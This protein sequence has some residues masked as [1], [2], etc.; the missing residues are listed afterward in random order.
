MSQNKFKD[1]TKIDNATLVRNTMK[2][3]PS[4]NGTPI[5]FQSG[6][7]EYEA[8][9]TT[10]SLFETV[11][12]YLVGVFF[13]IVIYKILIHYSIL[14]E[15]WRNNLLKVSIVIFSIIASSF[16]LSKI[17]IIVVKNL[18]KFLH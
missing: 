11:I 9:K 8:N 5:P 1:A 3:D 12:F 10:Q 15:E 7:S 6:Y 18:K 4:Q 17:S 2:A 14:N 16:I 13:S